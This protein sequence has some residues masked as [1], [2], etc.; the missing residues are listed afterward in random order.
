MELVPPILQAWVPG[1]QHDVLEFILYSLLKIAEL[2]IWSVW[3][4]TSKLEG[5]LL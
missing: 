2:E 5:W 4:E 1:S 3:I